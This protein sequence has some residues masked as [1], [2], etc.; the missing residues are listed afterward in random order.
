[1]VKLSNLRVLYIGENGKRFTKASKKY[2][3][4]LEFVKCSMQAFK[5]LKNEI[6]YSLIICEFELAGNNGL[7]FYETLQK[8]NLIDSIHFI[9]VSKVFN[10]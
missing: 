6:K 1:M 8:E 7:F 4:N 10:R 3:F 9:L 5:L 2:T